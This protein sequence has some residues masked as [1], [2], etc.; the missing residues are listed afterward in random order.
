VNPSVRNN[1]RSFGH[2]AKT[3]IFAHGYG[4]SQNIWRHVVSALGENFNIILYDLTGSGGSDK[5]AYHQ[6]RYHSLEGYA[7]DLI[8]ILEELEVT[9]VNFVGHSVGA[10]I[11][12]LAAIKRPE[13]FENLFL[14]TPSPCFID[15]S[16]YHGGF[17]SETLTNFI[18]SLKQ[19]L[20]RW[21][22]QVSPLMAGHQP[23]AEEELAVSIGQ[24]EPDIANHFAQVTFFSDYRHQLELLQTPSIIMQ[25]REDFFVPQEV[26]AYMNRLIQKSQLE[27]LDAIG[28]CPSLTHP[29]EVVR[30]INQYLAKD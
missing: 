30:I 26:G 18:N 24:Y 6:P 3:L 27:K 29:D 21:A 5:L 10:T 9:K 14:L 28:H 19:N 12:V 22:R 25:C 15:T 11:G 1:V 16:D 8:E 23:E 20:D 4:C 2:A 17:S 7:V 13:L